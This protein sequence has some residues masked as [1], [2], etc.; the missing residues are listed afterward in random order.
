MFSDGFCDAL[1][2]IYIYYPLF[3]IIYKKY[4]FEIIKLLWEGIKYLTFIQFMLLSKNK[5]GKSFLPV[6]VALDNLIYKPPSLLSNN[7]CLLY[8]VS[9]S[10]RLLFLVMVSSYHVYRLQKT[11]LPTKDFEHFTIS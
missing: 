5:G 4:R 9:I 6:G 11:K 10:Y 8:N 7:I 1:T 2:P 3:S